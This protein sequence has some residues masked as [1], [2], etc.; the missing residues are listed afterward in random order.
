MDDVNAGS[1]P[2]GAL[3]AIVLAG[4]RAT[5]LGRDKATLI[6]GGM[7]LLARTRQALQA[8]GC[9]PVIVVG[10]QVGGGPVAAIAGGLRGVESSRVLLVPTDLAD[11]AAAIARLLG[12]GGDRAGAG[13]PTA[14]DGAVLVDATGRE[15]WLT[16]IYATSALRDRLAQLGDPTDASVRALVGELRLARIP[17]GADATD[18]DTWEDYQRVRHQAP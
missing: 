13:D 17:A 15:Q 5:R 2:A 11:P 7:T 4:G 1:N 18:I 6:L 14:S 10:P 12:V 8:V 16:A 3:A 9:D